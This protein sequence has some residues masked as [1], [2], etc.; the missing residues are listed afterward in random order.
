MTLGKEVV[1]T[2]R[3]E[4][5]RLDTHRESRTRVILLCTSCLDGYRFFLEF[6]LN[7]AQL[8][9]HSSSPTHVSRVDWHSLGRFANTARAFFESVA[10]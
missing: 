5:D 4:M 10:F 8:L 6:Q 3:R 7:D 2:G 9:A 1:T